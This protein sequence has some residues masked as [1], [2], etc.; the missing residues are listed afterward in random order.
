MQCLKIMRAVL[1]FALA[2]LCVACLNIL[3][4]TWSSL[5]Q[6][7]DAYNAMEGQIETLIQGS[8]LEG[9]ID[10]N[11]VSKEFASN[12]FVFTPQSGYPEVSYYILLNALTHNRIKLAIAGFDTLQMLEVPHYKYPHEEKFYR[13]FLPYIWRDSKV[14]RYVAWGIMKQTYTYIFFKYASFPENIAMLDEMRQSKQYKREV[15]EKNSYGKGYFVS[16]PQKKPHGDSKYK[17]RR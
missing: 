1:F 10:K 9:H 16:T 12:T 8:P 14:F 11:I 13:C 3:L 7:F 6:K 17:W 4:L 5:E 15:K 2:V